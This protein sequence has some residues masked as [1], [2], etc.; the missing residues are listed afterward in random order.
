MHVSAC[1]SVCVC[2]RTHADVCV[3]RLKTTLRPLNE[4][5]TPRLSA[6]WS[7]DNRVVHVC[8]V[9][10]VCVRLIE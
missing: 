8:A 3:I 10:V 1:V 4:T 9:V 6:H 7:E 2:A 5:Q